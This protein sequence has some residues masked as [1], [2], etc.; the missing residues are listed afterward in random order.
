M[1]NAFLRSSIV[2]LFV[3]FFSIYLLPLSSSP[4]FTTCFYFF[5]IFIFFPL[6]L[7]L[8]F[9]SSFFLLFLFIFSS[10]FFFLLFFLIFLY[11]SSFFF[12]FLLLKPSSSSHK[13][14]VLLLIN[15]KPCE[16]NKT[17]ARLYIILTHCDDSR[18]IG[19]L[20][21]QLLPMLKAHRE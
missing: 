3:L 13:G 11:F 6:H 1:R 7:N 12:F 17:T 20:G 15:Q 8:R 21:R 10:D 2:S 9:L 4:S 18:V 19:L 14:V 16:T 5:H